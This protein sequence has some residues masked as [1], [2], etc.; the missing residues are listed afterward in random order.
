MAVQTTRLCPFLRFP[1][2]LWSPEAFLP[3]FRP[4]REFTRFDDGHPPGACDRLVAP[5]PLS[6]L[7]PS[8]LLPRRDFSLIK[9]SAF[10]ALAALPPR[11]P[12]K[13]SA[14]FLT[15]ENFSLGGKHPDADLRHTL[16]PLPQCFFHS[17]AGVFGSFLFPLGSCSFFFSPLR[18]GRLDPCS[19]EYS[20]LW[21][22]TCGKSPP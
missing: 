7:P 14:S 12:R 6:A 19:R 13:R 21:L 16:F 5:P 10:A 2:R 15:S 18:L 9:A 3:F 11:W 1:P 20:T 22:F 17:V 8:Y 4:F